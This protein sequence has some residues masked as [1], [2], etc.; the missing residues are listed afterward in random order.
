AER[1]EIGLVG[2]SRGRNRSHLGVGRSLLGFG[3]LLLGGSGLGLCDFL[4]LLGGDTRL[5]GGFRIGFGLGL[6]SLLGA[7][8][9]Q[10]RTLLLGLTR[11]LGRRPPGIFGGKLLK[12]QF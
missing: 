10:P 12:L 9:G 2:R 1:G 8:G 5:F 6:G 3:A 7:F 11:L 4:G